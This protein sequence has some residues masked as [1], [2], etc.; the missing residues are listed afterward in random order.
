MT[1]EPKECGRCDGCGQIADSKKGEPWTSWESMPY[2]S[3]VAI[4]MGLVRPITCPD[5]AGT[6]V[7]QTDKE[8][9]K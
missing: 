8:R 6:G 4:R 1:D 9:G 3:K 7:V 5:C 2:A